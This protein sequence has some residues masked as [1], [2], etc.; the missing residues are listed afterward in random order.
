ML[1]KQR[2]SAKARAPARKQPAKTKRSAAKRATKKTPRSGK[3][4]R[5]KRVKPKVK[6]KL[7]PHAQPKRSRRKPQPG[8]AVRGQA[9]AQRP[10]PPISPNRFPAGTMIFKF[11]DPF[12]DDRLSYQKESILAVTDLFKG[13]EACRTE[14]TVSRAQADGTQDQLIKENY[15]GYGN[16]LTLLDDEILANLQA[17][18]LR[19][20][21][22]PDSELNSGDFTVEME[23]GTGKTYSYLRTIFELNQRYGFTKFIIVVPSVAIKEGVF[24]S[25]KMTEAHF[26]SLY[27]NTPYRY[28]LYDSSVLSDVRTFALSG[29]IEIMVMTVQAINKSGDEAEAEAEAKDAVKAKEKSKNVIYRASEKTSGEKPIDL[30]RQTRPVL[31]VDE[32]QSVDGGLEGR[33]RQALARL[34]PLCTLRYSATHAEKHHMV[35]RL[36]AVDAY[37][38]NL[39]K[40]IEVAAARVES[41]NNKAYVR[42]LGVKNKRG[43]LTARVELDLQKGKTVQRKEIDVGIGSL[44]LETN[45]DIYADIQVT[46]FGT[47]KDGEQFLELSNLDRPLKVGEAIGALD[48]DSFTRQLFA[49][50]IEEHLKKELRLRPQG[51]KVLSLFFIDRVEHYRTYDEAGNR[52][53]GR[54][55]VL[56]EEEYRKAAK[57]PEF[58]TLF[59][60]V[61]LDTD[62]ADVHNGYFSKD[63]KKVGDKT[64]EIDKDTNGTTKADDDAYKLIMQDKERL[65]SFD[66]KLKFIFSHSALREGWDNPNVFQ[67]CSLREMG[68]ERER[69]QTIG[70]GLRICVNRD[71]DRVRSTGV[72]TLT[73]IAS[74][75]FEQYAEAL[76]AEIEKDTGIR[77]GIVEDHQ[78]ANIPV[79]VANGET[80]PLGVAQSEALWTALKAN[81]YINAQGK[82]QDKLRTALKTKTLVLPEAFQAQ[83]AQIEEILRKLAGKLEIKNA[84]ERHFIKAR[85]QV[86]DS[87]EFQALWDRIKY[88][89]SYEVEFD[90]EALIAKS[91]KALADGP[92]I[93]KTHLEW[94]TADLAIGRGGVTAAERGAARTI[95]LNES[96]IVLPDLLTDLQERTHLTR[97]SLVRIL[98][99]SGRIDDFTRNPQQFIEIAAECINRTKRHFLVD[100][101]KYQRLGDAY[102]Y[103]QSLFE[104]E[105]LTGYLKNMLAVQKSIY[106]QIVYQS[107][108]EAN[109]AEQMESNEAVKLFAKLPNWFKVPTP[110]GTYNPD[111]AVLIEKDGTE[112]LYFVVETKSGL[113]ADDVR[114][115]ES[116][117]MECGEAHFKA[118]AQGENPAVFKKAT[119]L[120]DILAAI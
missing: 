99:E 50:T 16:R 90:P 116:K 60:D 39:V 87:P 31:I 42:F 1:R 48:G 117:K 101:I 120:S 111:W 110:L 51:I 66:T 112:K 35:Y 30:I 85:K 77:F 27:A 28:F 67:I 20:G 8:V 47:N 23:T 114:D 3:V 62:A 52:G 94:R 11:E 5:P 84:D 38:R 7:R 72:N 6:T 106:E 34:N 57:R 21:L 33:G 95:V 78:F 55:Q 76:Q 54:Y 14:F 64:V 4:A 79:T 118:I 113:F 89:T 15:L 71:G 82:V 9:V 98:K 96:D 46:N 70:R 100:G 65:L 74:E 69:R 105:E 12:L 68:T 59:K 88:Q 24:K 56:F 29:T 32:P 19:H 80:V 86:L 17:V 108:T 73:I 115:K 93:K 49:R 103:A 22:K 45:R 92:S 37:N 104:Q 91:A 61:D 26:K 63:K 43:T 40:T 119:I 53:K 10:V 83:Q 41:G 2:K 75:P 97:R 36:D 44:E 13:Q 81:D 25:L 18:Q 107:D 109:F 102:F 58:N